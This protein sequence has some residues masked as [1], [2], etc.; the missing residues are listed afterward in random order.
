MKKYSI[1]EVIYFSNMKRPD[2]RETFEEL[3]S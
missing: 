2:E 1:E 3:E